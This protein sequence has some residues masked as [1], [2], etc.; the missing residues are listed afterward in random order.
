VYLKEQVEVCRQTK[1]SSLSEEGQM[2][3]VNGELLAACVIEWALWTGGVELWK[4]LF[5]VL[6]LLLESNMGA[7]MFHSGL[8]IRFGLVE[9]LMKFV[10]DAN[11][12]RYVL[13]ESGCESLISIFRHFN[14]INSSEAK[15]KVSTNVFSSGDIDGI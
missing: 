7:A 8:F 13:E 15:T 4:V 12:E 11:E 9:K 1:P 5:R 10:L 6:D 2:C 3:V 14:S